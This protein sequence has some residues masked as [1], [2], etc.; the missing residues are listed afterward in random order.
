M[1][2]E[3]KKYVLDGFEYETKEDYESALNEQKGIQFLFKKYYM[4]DSKVATTVYNNAIEKELFKTQTGINFMYE[5]RK[6]ISNTGKIEAEELKTIKIKNVD[7]QKKEE[8]QKLSDKIKIS[9][10]INC[11]L[12]IVIVAMIII[13]STSGNANIMNY[14]AKIQN[15]YSSW[16]SE[17][18]EREKAIKEKEAELNISN[19]NK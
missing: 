3:N 2:E 14:E 9:I 12:A 1:M 15:K 7:K 18:K 8:V 17:L 13:A 10:G 11:I 6:K 16:E 4:K 19:D 5:L